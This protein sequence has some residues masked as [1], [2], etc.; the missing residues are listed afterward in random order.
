MGEG[1]NILTPI[2]HALDS[3]LSA[4]GDD[5]P[6]VEYWS[7]QEYLNLEV[8]SDLDEAEFEEILRPLPS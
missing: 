4:I 6:I 7:R 3:F 1:G 5:N 8:H 2:E